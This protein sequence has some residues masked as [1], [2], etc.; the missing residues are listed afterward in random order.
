MHKDS[1]QCRQW[2]QEQKRRKERRK[3]RGQ[4]GAPADEE[5]PS[6]PSAPS[7]LD[8]QQSG[9]A[10]AEAAVEDALP[11][12]QQQEVPDGDAEQGLTSAADAFENVS[13][14]SN[15]LPG[16]RVAPERNRVRSLLNLGHQNTIVSF[17]LR[18]ICMLPA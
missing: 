9:S 12:Q 18:V 11:D 3:R 2:C 15:A 4:K 6:A 14:S 8:Q 5:Q 16:A 1:T 13:L 17:G 10:S 7:V